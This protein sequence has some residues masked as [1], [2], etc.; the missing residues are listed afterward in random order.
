MRA[1]RARAGSSL[2]RRPRAAG[3]PDRSWRARSLGPVLRHSQ[4]LHRL[5][6]PVWMGTLRRTSPVSD[7][8]GFDRGTP[9]DRYY[10][11]S[12]LE[13]NRR[14]H[15]W[16]SARDQELADTRT[17]SASDVERRDVLDVDPTNHDA[18]IVAD[19]AAAD[20][21][22]ADAFDCFILTQTLQL[23]YDA[24]S[25]IASMPIGSSGP[26]GVLL[27]SV[28]CVARIDARMHRQRPLA[29]HPR[30]VQRGS[31]VTCFAGTG[32]PC[33]RTAMFSPRSHFWPGWRTK[34]CGDASSSTTT[35]IS[36]CW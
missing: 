11:G 21:V 7:G 28:P 14:R 16:P 30:V 17:G 18:T 5:R 26:G 19:L 8:Y 10:I 29:L 9:V 4:R 23:I 33:E 1:A 32:S 24:S 15:P 35:R 20:G 3:H 2:R 25:A 34:S 13:E 27:C 31:S 6:H 36:R 22:P 12:F